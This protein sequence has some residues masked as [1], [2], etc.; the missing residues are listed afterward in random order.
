MRIPFDYIQSRI[1]TNDFDALHQGDKNTLKSK[2][3]EYSDFI[4][5][6]KEVN[7]E[8]M[9]TH[10]EKKWRDIRARRSVA[11]VIEAA[12][13]KDAVPIGERPASAVPANSSGLTGSL[14]AGASA[15]AGAASSVVDTARGAVGMPPVNETADQKKVREEAEAKAKAEKEAAD[16]AAKEK[17]EAEKKAKEEEYKKGESARTA[18]TN[19]V[20]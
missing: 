4:N 10:G 9:K 6:M 7:I 18:R 12:H 1:D 17:I 5:L 15:V 16:K 3:S 20:K 2:G 19:A 13:N 11:E 8:G 14:A